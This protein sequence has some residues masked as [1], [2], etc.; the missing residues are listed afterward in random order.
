MVFSMDLAD[1]TEVRPAASKGSH[2]IPLLAPA[3]PAP[4]PRRRPPRARRRSM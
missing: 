1:A 4:L 3:A 2:G